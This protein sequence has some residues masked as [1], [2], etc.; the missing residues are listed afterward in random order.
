MKEWKYDN[1]FY[2]VC[3]YMCVYPK[4]NVGVVKIIENVDGNRIRCQQIYSILLCSVYSKLLKFGFCI[5]LFGLML[6]NAATACLWVVEISRRR[7]LVSS[8]S[9]YAYKLIGL[10]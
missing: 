5:I 6:N 8:S 2:V 4:V 9:F 10:R 7:A 3:T 1:A